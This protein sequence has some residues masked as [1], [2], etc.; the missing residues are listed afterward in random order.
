MHVLHVIDSLGLGGAERMLVDIANATVADH[1]RVS[2]CVTRSDVA[3]ESELDARIELLVLGRKR[4]FDFGSA[5]QFIRWARAREIDVVHV[6]MRSSARFLV[7]LKIVR[8]LALPIVFH[9]HFGT[10]EI[11]QSVPTWFRFGRRSIDHYVGVYSKLEDWAVRA[12]V[13]AERA[14]T[15]PNGLALARI[16]AGPVHDLRQ[17]L[18]LPSHVSLGIQVASVRRDKALEIAIDALARTRNRERIHIAIVGVESDVSY[19][20]EC[21]ARIAARG[22]EGSVTFI[23]GRRDVP[24][25]LRSADF[26]VLSSK[27]ESGPLV[28][29]EYLA[30]RI[31]IAATR[32]GDIGNRLAQLAV[33]GF[34]AANDVDAL[35]AAI[36][37]IVELEPSSRAIRVERGT[38]V[39][40]EGWDIVAILPRW[41]EVYRSAMFHR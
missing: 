26:G 11:D 34:V 16:T 32:V 25:L 33:P 24:N 23:G 19:G 22:L 7:A 20:T 37:E 38:A 12:G 39:V 2:V 41:Y 5:L 40:R 14:S 15:I 30:A 28:L 10:I 31:P 4:T 3:L 18:H 21:R 1:H 27:T 13:P 36:D 17:E 9:D 6:H 8:A 29:I 35:A